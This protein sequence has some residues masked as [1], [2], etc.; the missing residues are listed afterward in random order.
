MTETYV[1]QGV[2][3][4][5]KKGDKMSIVGINGSGKST[6]VK[7]ILGL[8]KIN[9]GIILINGH[10]MEEYDIK[11][12]RKLF[13][14]LFQGFVQYPLTLRENIALSDIEKDTD[15]DEAVVSAMKKSGVY[16]EIESKLNHGL[17]SYMTRQFD[18]QEGS[19]RRLLWQE[20]IIKMRR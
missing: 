19:G 18:Y 5:L 16:D 20:R 4:V 12:V 2:D 9:S 13:S 3:F 6:I 14:V 8:Y 7:L 11:D 10:P 17:D 1:L 15:N